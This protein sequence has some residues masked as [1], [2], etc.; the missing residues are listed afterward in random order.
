LSILKCF[1]EGD[2]YDKFR[3]RRIS[4]VYE[5]ESLEIPPPIEMICKFSDIPLRLSRISPEPYLVNNDEYKWILY[6][7]RRGRRNEGKYIYSASMIADGLLPYSYV[8][9]RIIDL[10]QEDL[11]EDRRIKVIYD[12]SFYGLEE[13]KVVL[14]PF[15]E[16]VQVERVNGGIL[17]HWGIKG[18]GELY[19]LIYNQPRKAINVEFKLPA[20]Y[21]V[22]L[23]G[24]IEGKIME[25]YENIHVIISSEERIKNEYRVIAFM[26]D[27]IL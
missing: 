14:G 17:K 6:P 10:R 4:F 1:L 5:V 27:L 26:E 20:H 15:P 23:T 19:F 13:Y 9:Y 24:R 7:K 25:G 12:F 3:L 8:D 21:K 2:A 11:E 16:I 22:R 18:Y